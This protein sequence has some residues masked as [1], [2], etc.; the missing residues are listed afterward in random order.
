MTFQVF[1][2]TSVNQKVSGRRPS[3]PLLPLLMKSFCTA[4]EQWAHNIADQYARNY[5]SPD[6]VP[7]LPHYKR[8]P[9]S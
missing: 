4:W 3:D 7:G 9:E 8:E 1:L 5:S 6:D 2:T